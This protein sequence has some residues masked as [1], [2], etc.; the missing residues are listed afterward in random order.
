MT[1]IKKPG[2]NCSLFNDSG[3]N[4]SEQINLN[5][6]D[7]CCST[8]PFSSSQTL[9][10]SSSWWTHRTQVWELYGPRSPNLRI[11]YEVH[12]C[13]F[14]S[15]HLFLAEWNYDVGNREV[16]AIK[17]ALEEWRHWL[18]AAKQHFIVWTD[19]KNRTHLQNAK[20]WNSHQARWSMFF[21]SSLLLHCLP[22]RLP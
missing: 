19:H 20:R 2:L 12:P 14:S 13:A 18:E 5:H 10:S 22:S 4:Q 9:I 17:L 1:V 3:T 15:Q 7:P 8:N 6:T 21:G 16:L 11:R